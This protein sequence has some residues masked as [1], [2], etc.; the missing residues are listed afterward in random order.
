[1]RLLGRIMETM[2]S[3]PQPTS[4]DL[5]TSYDVVRIDDIRTG[6]HAV[7]TSDKMD[8]ESA[9]QVTRLFHAMEM[10]LRHEINHRDGV[11]ASLRADM[12]QQRIQAELDRFASRQIHEE[13]MLASTPSRSSKFKR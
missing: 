10:L 1:M 8:K 11:I 6:I 12:H 5:P 7:A 3:P 4:T 9:L 2:E 13:A